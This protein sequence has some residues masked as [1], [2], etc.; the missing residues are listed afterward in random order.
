MRRHKKMSDVDFNEKLKRILS[1]ITDLST[2]PG[3]ADNLTQL[4]EN[5]KTSA[6]TV[7]DSIRMDPALTSKVLKLVN[8]AF[9]GFPRKIN[10]L[11]QAV[12][13]LGFNNIKNIILTAS[14]FNI[15]S[16]GKACLSFN[17]EKFWEHSMG[18]GVV[19]KVMTKRLGIKKYEEA[20]IGGL[21]HDI[22]RLLLFQYLR[23]EFG[24]IIKRVG[25]KDI[26]ISEA[27]REVLGI[28]HSFIGKKLG[29]HWNLPPVLEEVIEFH[30]DPK[31]ALDNSRMASVVHLADI[32]TRALGL[33]SGGDEKI[34]VIDETAM[35]LLDIDLSF[36]EKLL[37]EVDEEMDKA[38]ELLSLID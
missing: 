27:E 28:D 29:E 8:S 12:V 15:F 16:D 2:L 21:L 23:D 38:R 36:I 11:S 10:T 3:I 20:F 32:I 30:H 35:E 22:G 34:P 25:E 18:C 5:P 9:Y 19:S 33:G 6:V 4:I 7:G 14:I 37:P 13:I 1:S 31:S 24:E 26:L 17:V